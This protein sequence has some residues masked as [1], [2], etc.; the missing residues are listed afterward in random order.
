MIKYRNFVPVAERSR[1]KK[2]SYKPIS[3]LNYPVTS[4][5]GDTKTV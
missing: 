5:T 1:S 3:Y 4:R 2:I